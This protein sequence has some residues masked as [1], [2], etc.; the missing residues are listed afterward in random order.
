M[1]LNGFN[2]AEYF[3]DDLVLG[4]PMEGD[5]VIGRGDSMLLEVP[6]STLKKYA[7]P[8]R[9]LT[10][11]SRCTRRAN[12]AGRCA[13]GGTCRSGAGCCCGGCTG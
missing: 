5:T 8:G 2:L 12:P 1:T 9:R 7:E 6:F 11:E 13:T 10:A 3:V 4:N